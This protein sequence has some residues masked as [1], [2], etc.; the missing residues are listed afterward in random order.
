MIGNDM[1][2]GVGA[3]PV[4]PGQTAVTVGLPFRGNIKMGKHK[5]YFSVVAAFSLLTLLLFDVFS[6]ALTIMLGIW[7]TP[8]MCCVDK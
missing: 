6:S 8:G 1:G 5:F 2:A 7:W 3:L 4:T